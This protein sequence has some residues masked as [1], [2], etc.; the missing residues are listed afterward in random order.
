MRPSR[1][2]RTASSR[3]RESPVGRVPTAAMTYGRSLVDG[4]DG[5]RRPDRRPRGVVDLGRRAGRRP[6]ARPRPP[7]LG[8]ATRRRPLPP[9]PA[10][11]SSSALLERRPAPAS[12]GAGVQVSESSGRRRPAGESPGTSTRRPRRSTH[13]VVPQPPGRGAQVVQ[14]HDPGA[15]RADGFVEG[16]D[17]GEAAFLGGQLGRPRG[18]RRPPAARP[19][20]E[21]TSFSS[22]TS[23]SS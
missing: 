20:G 10:P 14:R 17:R 22:C 15:R 8:R 12:G 2:A 7:L 11:A 21:R 19:A 5:G 16:G 3:R 4:D 9:P 6:P 1:R 23:G 18:R 13:S